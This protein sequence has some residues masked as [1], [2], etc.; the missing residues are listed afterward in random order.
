MPTPRRIL[1]PPL[2]DGHSPYPPGRRGPPQPQSHP[3]GRSL[4]PSADC[5]LPMKR[6]RRSPP[7]IP[8]SPTGPTDIYHATCLNDEA[9]DLDSDGALPACLSLSY[10]DL[11]HPTPKW[12]VVENLPAS[13]A[14]AAVSF[15]TAKRHLHVT[16]HRPSAL[17]PQASGASAASEVL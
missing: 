6:P 7:F 16:Q 1:T 5:H 17:G 12:E 11:S 2:P 14:P 9:L 3:R 15:A 13:P 4:P 10:H 8:I